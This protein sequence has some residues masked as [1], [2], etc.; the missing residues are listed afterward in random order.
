MIVDKKTS[1]IEVWHKPVLINE[2][3]D[4]LNP[5]PGKTYLDVTFGSGGH[6]HAILEHEPNCNVIGMDWDAL[7]LE[8]YAPLLQQKF[9]DR[10][11]I[12]WGN[13]AQSYRLLKKAGIKKVDGI[14]ADFGT[15]YMHIKERPGF[16]FYLDTPLDMRMSPAHQQLTAAHVIKTASQEKLQEIFFQLGEEKQAKKI[17]Y[18]I[19]QKRR[20]KPI[21]TT[22]DLA[23]IIERVIPRKGRKIHPAT[24]IFQALRMYINQELNN[25]SAFLSASL[26]LLN[27]TGRLVCISFHS[28]EDRLV[29]Q[30]FK[31]HEKEGHLQ[32]LT[33]K[34][35]V[36][37]KKEIEKNSSSRS[38]K[39]R[40]AIFM[41]D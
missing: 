12:I 3:L 25:I 9:G 31:E 13:F 17:A 14:L 2:V 21:K 35:V 11:Q 8:T 10:L 19:V 40:A 33:K 30:F 38:A 34:V 4:Y 15:S 36:P 37:T 28:L 23:I 41:G 29:K 18:V 20:E 27:T 22:R 5:Q 16:S 7:S 1:T 26:S 32:I 6:S 24:K 39:L